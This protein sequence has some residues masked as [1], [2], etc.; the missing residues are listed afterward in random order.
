MLSELSQIFLTFLQKN[1]TVAVVII[2]V[3]LA[4]LLLRRM[5]KKYSYVLWSLVGIRM[6]FDLPIASRLSVFNLF[7][8]FA[9][10]ASTAETMLSP[11][12]VTNPVGTTAASGAMGT[13]GTAASNAISG[14]AAASVTAHSLSTTQMILGILGWIWLIGVGLFVAY[15]IYSYIKCRMLVQTAILANDIDLPVSSRSHV[16]EGSESSG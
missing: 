11:K 14:N 2:A 3:L 13:T 16:S 5:P 6:I 9:G 10:R 8:S 7:R 12:G 4:R 15:G 1:M